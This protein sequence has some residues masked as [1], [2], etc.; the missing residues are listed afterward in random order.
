MSIYLG[1]LTVEQIEKRLGIEFSE[2]ER[3]ELNETRENKANNIPIGKWHCF[4][5]PFTIACGGYDF[6]E[7]IKEILTSY[8]NGMKGQIGICV[9]EG[10]DKDSRVDLKECPKCGGQMW[11][12]REPLQMPFRIVRGWLCCECQNKIVEGVEV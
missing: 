7:R 8:V 9:D 5:I 2:S 6:A 4:D 3:K 12:F 10:D 1:N 11:R